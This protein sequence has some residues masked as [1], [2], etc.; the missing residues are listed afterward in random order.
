MGFWGFEKETDKTCFDH[1]GDRV[2][3]SIK[4]EARAEL[5]HRGYSEEKIREEEWKRT[6]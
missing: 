2:P 5:K 1:L 6:K 3:Y 4:Q